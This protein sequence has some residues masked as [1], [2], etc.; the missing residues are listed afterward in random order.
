MTILEK[1]GEDRPGGAGLQVDAGFFDRTKTAKLLRKLTSG[2]KKSIQLWSHLES[3]LRREVQSYSGVDFRFH[4][5]VEAVGQDDST[6]WVVTDTGEIIFGDIL[7][8]ADGH[9]S[10]VREQVAPQKPN[11]TFSGYMVWFAAVDEKE[12]PASKRPGDHVPEFTMLDGINGG[13]FF[14]S[15]FNKGKG[16]SGSGRRRI[17]ST[18]YDNTRNDLLRRLGCVKGSVVHHSLKGADIPEETLDKLS[19]QARAKWPEPWVSATLHA[20]RTRNLTGIP[21]KEYVPDDLVKE[22]IALIGDAAHVPAPITAS[23][24]N[25]SLQDAAELGKCVAKG[26]K[27][28]AAVK[29]LDKYESLRLN[30]VRQMVQSGKSFSYSYGRS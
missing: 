19:E 9:R 21:I 13:F 1:A 8:G 3:N 29:A 27:G 14:G 24:F 4:T 11:A 28:E 18:F 30:K 25:E 23:G 12:L 16:S 7:I 6:A 5:R 17:G 20:I 22:R 26:I 15:V 2:G 10:M